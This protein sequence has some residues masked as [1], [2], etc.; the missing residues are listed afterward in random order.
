MEHGAPAM[1]ARSGAPPPEPSPWEQGRQRMWL[2]A[3]LGAG[4]PGAR[5]VLAACERRCRGSI[6]CKTVQESKQTKLKTALSL[7]AQ[8]WS[9]EQ[10][11][12]DLRHV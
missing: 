4:G 3:C 12:T 7:C 11:V 9:K 10:G 5:V 2:H 6:N 1:P 8:R